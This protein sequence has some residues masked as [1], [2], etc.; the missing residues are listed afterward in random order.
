MEKEVSSLSDLGETPSRIHKEKCICTEGQKNT[1]NYTIISVPCVKCLITFV[2]IYL[3]GNYKF[4][5]LNYVL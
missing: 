5:F 4:K 3:N 1:I 2:L